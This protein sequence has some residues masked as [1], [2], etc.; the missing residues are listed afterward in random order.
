MSSQPSSEKPQ[1]EQAEQKKSYPPNNIFIGKKPLMVY[2]LSAQLQLS[3]YPE[4]VL[5]AR[6]R[7][8]S[9]AVDVAQVL[10]NRIGKD[11]YE[12]GSI[13]IGTEEVGEGEQKRNVST[14]EI[15]IKRKK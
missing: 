4:V 2:A 1:G 9:K 14:I 10:V 11:L 6:G 7:A 15:V 13:N 8:I 3:T 5:R 12:L